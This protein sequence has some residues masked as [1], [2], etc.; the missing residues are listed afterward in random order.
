[1]RSLRA[2]TAPGLCALATL[3]IF[4]MLTPGTAGADEWTHWR[5]P[6]HDG[7]ASATGLPT[8]WSQDGENLIWR[9]DFT[10]R[11][12]PVVFDGRVC[13]TGRH[14]EGIDRLEVAACWDAE[15]GEKLWEQ[16]WPVYLTAVP[17]TRVS[18]GDPAADSETGYMFVQGV[19]GR[20][21]AFDRDGN[22]AWEREL[23]QDFGRFS[24]YGGRTNS[25]I[26][27]ENRVIVHSISSLWGPHRPGG[28]R[29]IAFDKR[30][31]DVLWITNR[32]GPPAGDLNT[33]STPMVA[34]INGQRLMIAGGADGFIRAINARSGAEVWKFQLSKRGLNAS[35]VVDG[36][37]VYASHGEENLDTSL[38]GR[39]VAIDGSGQGDI[40][41]SGVLWEI[42]GLQAGFASPT[43]HDGVLYVP[44][45]SANIHAYD[46]KTGEEIWEYNY[47]TVGKG[48]PV[49][50]EGRLYITETNGYMLI[51][52]PSK[53]GM[54]QLDKDFIE[55]PDGTR[56]AEIYGSVAVAY[57]RI[58]FTTEEGIYCI[59][60]KEKA[61]EAKA[62]EPRKLA[63]KPKDDKA[64]PAL[65][66]VV[67][68]VVVGTAD[69]PQSF[70]VQVFDAM[71][72][73]HLETTDATWSLQG[74]P[75]KI[76]DK[77]HVTFDA[78]KVS[79]TQVG[80]VTAKIGDLEA[81][82]H[83]RIAGPL[84]WTE[85]FDDVEIGKGPASWL[86]LGKG[87][88]VQELDG[89][90]VLLQPKAARGA[91]RATILVGPS[92]MSGYTVQADIRG[93]TIGRRKTDLGVVNSGYT[94]ELQGNHQ[95][96]QV[97][98]WT[99]ELRMAQRF[100]FEWEMGVWYTLKMRVDYEGEG[101]AAK[102]IIRGKA[103]KRGD[104]EPAD[105]NVTVE[106]PHP[107]RQGAP[108]IYTFAP[109]ES[110]FDNV[111]V[112]VSE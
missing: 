102:A 21:V 98:S 74:L 12:T 60:D 95:R 15:N 48:S 52:E 4:A 93:N 53:E 40:T 43:I 2:L 79:G 92:S 38:M 27:D 80:T 6:N 45:N 28:D 32:N 65:L 73:L 84:P 99:S 62:G 35:V 82:S 42:D 70:R 106:D 88:T 69:E 68:G 10:G 83:L 58:Y 108:G 56:Y 44:D 16:R 31:G 94:F 107:I 13:A 41:A 100:P 17:W 72:H 71:G 46:A 112:M 39:L 3:C 89:E 23:G 51:L 103:W 9:A 110:Y 19:N 90:K 91:P 37:T 34:T 11:S 14:G 22:V 8:T 59:G 47:G 96:I 25:P 36:S 105:W 63:E 97:S 87:A 29:Y 85:D 75:G 7:T 77:G 24:G 26:V 78:S 101:D 20:F 49:W 109:V 5:G 76:D 111:K 67:P 61:F 81:V 57:D 66:R 64:K 30:T 86:G 55:I 1:M 18:W 50:A 33:Y 104:A 54:K